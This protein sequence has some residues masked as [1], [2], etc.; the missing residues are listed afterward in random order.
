MKQLHREVIG[1]TVIILDKYILCG[2]TPNDLQWK[3]VDKTGRSHIK[4]YRSLKVLLNNLCY[5]LDH[6][7]S[8]HFKKILDTELD[9]A[10]FV[11]HSGYYRTSQKEALNY[12]IDIGL[13]KVV[14]LQESID[15]K[16]E[17]R[18]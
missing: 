12:L 5:H 3:E 9:K 17:V 14:E 1:Y 2:T 11:E 10:G 4:Y 15:I 6:L 8:Q 7:G 16:K 18:F 13:L